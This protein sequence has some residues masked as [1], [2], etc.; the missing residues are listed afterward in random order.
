M[1]IFYES[2]MVFGIFAFFIFGI[3]FENSPR[4]LFRYVDG[5]LYVIFTYVLCSSIYLLSIDHFLNSS[6]YNYLL[7]RDGV[8]N[9][10]SIFLLVGTLLIGFSA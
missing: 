9:L 1:A 2:Q 7:V 4:E 6:F 5:I 3:I 10:I 8:T